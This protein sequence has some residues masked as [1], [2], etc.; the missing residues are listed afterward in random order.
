MKQPYEN[1][2]KVWA[3][4][5]DENYKMIG[6]LIR[7]E[8]G[9]LLPYLV[10][11]SNGD[12]IYGDTTWY[13]NIEPYKEPTKRPMTHTEVFKLMQENLSKGLMTYFRVGNNTIRT[14]W[15]SHCQI[16]KYTY[17]TDLENWYPLEVEE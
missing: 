5:T 2:P 9:D 15:G 7:T 14:Y 6:Y 3:W 16:N 1:L 8:D 12:T 10:L 4:T 17:S 11:R 13:K